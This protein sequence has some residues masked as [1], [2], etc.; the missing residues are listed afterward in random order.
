MFFCSELG[1][2]IAVLIQYFVSLHAFSC[3]EQKQATQ[4]VQ[5]QAQLEVFL[6]V[7]SYVSSFLPSIY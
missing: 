1:E 4:S 2:D 3:L 5:A 6:Y 7:R